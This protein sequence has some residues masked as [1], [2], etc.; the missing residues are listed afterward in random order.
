MF[1]RIRLASHPIEHSRRWVSRTRDG[2]TLQIQLFGLCMLL[3]L[4]K[5]AS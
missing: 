5:K 3:F 2:S 4:R 1:D